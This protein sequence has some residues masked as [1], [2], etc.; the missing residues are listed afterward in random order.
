MSHTPL[1]VL[2]SEEELF[3]NEV[4]K[5]AQTQV[6]PLVHTMDE[7]ETMDKNLL[8]Q[9]FELGLMGIEVPTEFGGSGGS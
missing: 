1:T 4:D 3:V 8:G 5:F 7:T 9:M 2:S 6:K